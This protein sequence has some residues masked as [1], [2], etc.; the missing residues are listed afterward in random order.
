MRTLG[1][2][3]VLAIALPAIAGATEVVREQSR[4]EQDPQGL[5]TVRIDNA[6]GV[7]DLRRSPDGVL[8]ISAL[9]VARSVSASVARD[10]A[11]GT[12]VETERNGD[13][14]RIVVRYPKHRVKVTLFSKGSIPSVEVRLAVEVPDRLTAVVHTASA[15]VTTHDLP[16]SQR[17]RTASGDVVVEGGAGALEV[18]TAS[19]DVNCTDPGGAVIVSTTS[20][21]IRVDGA[22][23]SLRVRTVSG[24]V[25]VERAPRGLDLESTSGGVDVGPSAGR[26][27]VRSM[28][29]DVEVALAGA[30]SGADIRSQSGTLTLDLDSRVACSLSAETTH[31]EINFRLPVQARNLSRG[32]VSVTIRGGSTPV[33]LR[34]VSGDINVMGGGR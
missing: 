16:G 15:D 13:E 12:V 8:R 9:K 17:L 3:A 5:T 24:E 29:G 33:H 18:G 30:L 1:L 31:G 22:S 21:D 11:R 4:L 26:V 25:L 14:Y 19:G 2:M 10:L 32:Q 6:R 23:D 7:V 20:G 28:S 34:T 27:R